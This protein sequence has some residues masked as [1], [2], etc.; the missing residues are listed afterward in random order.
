MRMASL[1]RCSAS[2]VN[3]EGVNGHR[4]WIQ[5]FREKRNSRAKMQLLQ[6]TVRGNI[7]AGTTGSKQRES[8]TYG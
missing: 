3:S 2:A 6:L 4:A 7:L 8:R 5:S 1:M